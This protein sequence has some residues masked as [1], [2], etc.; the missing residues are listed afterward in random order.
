M[1]LVSLVS[2]V[3]QAIE[4]R[5]EK[6]VGLAD[7]KAMSQSRSPYRSVARLAE[8]AASQLEEQ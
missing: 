7:E 2:A 6:S 5:Y 8:Y 3:E 4:D 1:G